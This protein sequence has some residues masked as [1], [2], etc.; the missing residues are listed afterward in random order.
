MDLM[1]LSCVAAFSPLVG[2]MLAGFLGWK[3]G[4]RFSHTVA[5][6]SVAISFAAS[7]AALWKVTHGARLDAEVYTWLAGD[8]WK[9][10]LG[11]LIDRLTV[12]MMCVVTFVSLMVHVYTIG[13]M[14]DDP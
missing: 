1:T 4:R 3:L 13:Y 5:I 6:A 2:A 9:M 14:A 10:S 12:T 11:F 8:G 7:L